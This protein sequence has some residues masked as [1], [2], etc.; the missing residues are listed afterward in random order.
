VTLDEPRDHQA[1]IEFF[2][3]CIGDNVLGN[4]DD[5]AAAMAMST[6][7][8]LASARRACRNTRSTGIRA[9]DSDPYV[10]S[11]LNVEFF[12]FVR[13]GLGAGNPFLHE[14]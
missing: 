14:R 4:V 1:A 3:R 11:E 6:S 13:L 12:Q 2:G 10:G 7:R 9:P 8:S 5:V